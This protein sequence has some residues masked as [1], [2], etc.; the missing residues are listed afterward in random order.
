AQ[1]KARLGTKLMIWDISGNSPYLR[2]WSEVAGAQYVPIA[3]DSDSPEFPSALS[4]AISILQKKTSLVIQEPIP[5]SD[6]VKMNT[7]VL[8]V[9][10]KTPVP[11]A[12]RG[13][14]LAMPPPKSIEVVATARPSKRR[15]PFI[16][17]SIIGLILL[18]LIT[19]ASRRKKQNPAAGVVASSI[20]WE[21][22]SLIDK[23]IKKIT[24]DTRARLRKMARDRF[25]GF[26]QSP[27]FYIR[28]PVPPGA[29]EVRWIDD[30]GQ[31][32]NA[33]VIT[34]SP[35]GLQFATNSFAA[36]SIGQISCP[37]LGRDFNVTRSSVHKLD[38]SSVFVVLVEFENNTDA[39]MRWIE[40]LTR[41]DRRK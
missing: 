36:S 11:P 18:G 21:L 20:L 1:L 13:P 3:V 7:V 37:T 2:R 16:L 9:L 23:R 31:A 26:N 14:E 30:R 29:M 41:I 33:P 27:E 8:E 22:F 15:W 32:G 24:S 28:I 35:R 38:R 12:L 4:S 19:P 25:T 39:W 40:L 6:E 17:A 10:K 5:K 34:I